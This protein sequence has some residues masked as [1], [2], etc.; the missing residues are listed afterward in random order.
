MLSLLSASSPVPSPWI[1][2]VPIGAIP[3]GQRSR[4]VLVGAFGTAPLVGAGEVTGG[5]E[6]SLRG[7]SHFRAALHVPPGLSPHST[8]L[9]PVG[10]GFSLFSAKLNWAHLTHFSHSSCAIEG[11]HAPLGHQHSVYLIVK[12]TLNEYLKMLSWSSLTSGKFCFFSSGLCTCTVRSEKCVTVNATLLV[13]Q[14]SWRCR[15]KPSEF[16]ILPNPEKTFEKQKCFF[17]LLGGPQLVS[18][19][20]LK[21]VIY[22]NI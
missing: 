8:C 2:S 5:T 18:A 6:A 3:A 1:H 19:A 4:L 12:T 20:L 11:K 9:T 15:I 22:A 17:S 7:K 21:L 14:G 16:F 13:S 10:A